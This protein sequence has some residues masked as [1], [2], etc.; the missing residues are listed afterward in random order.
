MGVANNRSI[1]YGIAKVARQHGADLAFTYQGDA[2][3]KRVEPL[4]QALGGH[5]VGHCDVT[6]SASLDAV[7]AATAQ[8]WGRLDF[9]VHAIAFSDRDELTGRYVETSE[10]NFTKSLLISC[11]SFTAVAQRAEKLMPGGGSLLTLTY[12]GAEKWMPHY[13]VMGVAKAA[14]EASVRY[15]AADLGPGGIR[16][17]AI[18]AGPIKTLAA[19][20]IGDFR[21][22]LKWN[23]YNSP[24]RRTVTIEEVG[25]TASYLVSDMSRGVTGE[26]LHVDAGYHVVGMKNP[27]APDLSLEREQ[28]S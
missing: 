10:A 28:A 4:A 3:R 8:L 26:I 9:V 17:N 6:D 12:Y 21:Y 2:L 19:S 13:N 15:L 16:V 22:I 14:L 18:S 23:E 27:D 1:A 24:L 5:V 20:G 7:F 25:E 11:Y